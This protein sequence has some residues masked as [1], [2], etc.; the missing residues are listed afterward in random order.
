MHR[1]ALIRLCAQFLAQP[2]QSS[3]PTLTPRSARTS[4]RLHLVRLCWHVPGHTRGAECPPARPCRRVGRTDS[5][6]S[7]FAP[8]LRRGRLAIEF[9]SPQRS[10]SRQVLSGPSPITPPRLLRKHTRSQGPSLH[11][12]Y[13][14]SAMHTTLS[15]SRT[16][17]CPCSTVEAATLVQHGSPPLA[18][19]PVST[20]RA[21]LPRWTGPGASVGCFPRTVLPS[22]NSGRVRRPQLPFRE[23]AQALFALRPA[24]SLRRPRRRRRFVAGLRYDQLPRSHRLPATGPTDH[25][26]GGT[27]THEVIAGPSGRTKV[28]LREGFL[29]ALRASD[30]RLQQCQ[31]GGTGLL[32]AQRNRF[33]S[34]CNFVCTP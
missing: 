8:G 22:P 17:R 2:G 24:D 23:P 5:P 18:Q 12:H 7:A 29:L 21:P 10:G 19:S 26:P 25:C 20:C 13:P 1:L 3:P 34:R 28:A 11:R 15:D 30:C 4:S 6:G 14:A 32:R 27:S 31:C 9:P 16:D 33:F